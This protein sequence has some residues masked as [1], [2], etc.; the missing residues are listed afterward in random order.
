MSALLFLSCD[1]P[2]YDGRTSSSSRPLTWRH[3]RWFLG[4]GFEV[5]D[6][7]KRFGMQFSVGTEVQRGSPDLAACASCIEAV[8]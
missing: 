7:V 6:R 2:A 3:K 8:V 1:A 5:E 4:L